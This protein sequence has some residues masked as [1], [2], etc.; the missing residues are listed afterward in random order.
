MNALSEK[1][2]TILGQMAPNRSYEPSELR[3]FAPDTSIESLREVMHELWVKRYVERFGYSGWRRDPSTRGSEEPP[4]SES[5]VNHRIAGSC[6]HDFRPPQTKAV[7]PEDL[8][9]HDS[10]S[11]F[12][13]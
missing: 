8:F 11:G 2:T 5:R 6:G 10:F 13:K 12:F 3:A 7:T 9:D 1:A 4:D